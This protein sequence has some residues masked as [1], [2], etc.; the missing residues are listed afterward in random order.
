RRAHVVCSTGLRTLPLEA[1]P[2]HGVRRGR[3]VLRPRRVGRSAAEE[4]HARLHRRREGLRRGV[5]SA[6]GRGECLASE[7]A[8]GTEGT[9]RQVTKAT[10][11][12]K[13][14]NTRKLDLSVS[15]LFVCFVCFAVAF[16]RCFVSCVIPFPS[17]S[18]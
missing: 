8:D 11:A 3:R 12:R 15:R 10:K 18:S 4:P 7:T 2:L 13:S 14:R 9:E 1:A 5:R 6:R 17:V 16:L